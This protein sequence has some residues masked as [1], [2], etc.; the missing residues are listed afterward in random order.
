MNYPKFI[1]ITSTGILV[2]TWGN[3]LFNILTKPDKPILNL[4]KQQK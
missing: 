4:D 2:G 3:I 1:F